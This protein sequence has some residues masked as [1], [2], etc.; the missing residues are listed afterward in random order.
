[1]LVSKEVD[2]NKSERKNLAKF[3][4]LEIC[5]QKKKLNNLGEGAY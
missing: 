3:R 1:M 5:D 2:S 4:R